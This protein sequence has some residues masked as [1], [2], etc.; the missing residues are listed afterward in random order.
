MLFGSLQGI[1]V[2]PI[3]DDADH[4]AINRARLT[5]IDDGLQVGAAA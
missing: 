4:P 2:G 1:G 5:L 3:A